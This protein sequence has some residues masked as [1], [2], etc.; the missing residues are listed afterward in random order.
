MLL[1]VCVLVYVCTCVVVYHAS[2]LE[3]PVRSL[4]VSISGTGWETKLA[5]RSYSHVGVCVCLPHF[6]ANCFSGQGRGSI[7]LSVSKVDRTRGSIMTCLGPI[8]G[9][10]AT[11]L[12]GCYCAT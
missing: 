7:L 12:V 6:S 3:C 1:C 5:N 4:E 8:G 11:A 9:N 2:P 10:G